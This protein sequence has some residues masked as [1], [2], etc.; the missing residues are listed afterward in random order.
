MLDKKGTPYWRDV[1]GILAYYEAN[2][3]LKETEPK[4]D[5]YNEKWPIYNYHYSLPPAKFVHNEELGDAG[6]PRVGKSINSIVCDGCVLSGGTVIDS[7]LFNSVR[8]H[9][10]ATINNSVILS[11]V[12]I[13]Q[14]CRIKNAIID[15]HN[16]I[17]EGT[18]IG[19]NRKEDEKKYKVFDLDKEKG[20]WLTVLSKN[21]KFSKPKLPRSI[22]P[23]YGY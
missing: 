18:T 17:P 2:M 9:S 11:D 6:M 22:K 14:N 10:Y 15:K 20:T 3:D 1:G 4:L 12:N 5:L 8:I 23:D 16:N 19:Y 7:V 21:R 13:G